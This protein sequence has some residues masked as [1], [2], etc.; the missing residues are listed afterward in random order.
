MGI[1]EANEREGKKNG[2]DE[3]R[4]RVTRPTDRDEKE[5][6]NHKTHLSPQ[7]VH[8]QPDLEEAVPHRVQVRH[9][10]LYPLR[11]DAHQ[12]R[13]LARPAVR[14]ALPEGEH[15]GLAVYR[16]DD[17]GPHPEP[18]RVALAGRTG[19]EGVMPQSEAHYDLT[20]HDCAPPGVVSVASSFERAERGQKR[21]R[22]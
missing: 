5:E 8:G 22:R 4:L 12:V 16:D 21:Q 19:E 1:F 20:A 2:A 3:K 7:E 13:D 15:E 10:V 6:Y 18:D 11:V 14:V 9:E 17:G